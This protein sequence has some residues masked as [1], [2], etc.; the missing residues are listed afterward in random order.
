M[1]EIIVAKDQ[2]FHS[3]KVELDGTNYILVLEW[4]MRSGWYLGLK[5]AAGDTIFD[6]KK[7][8]EGSDILRGQTDPRCPPGKL[9]VIDGSGLGTRPGYESFESSHYLVYL[10]LD[11]I[12]DLLDFE[13]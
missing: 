10:S 2:P 4:N 1:P 7:L 12:E 9:A 8:V 6:P 11:E 5:D 13:G 3:L